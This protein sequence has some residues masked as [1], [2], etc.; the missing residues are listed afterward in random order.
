MDIKTTFPEEVWQGRMHE[1][2]KLSILLESV[3]GQ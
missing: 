3:G 2:R 1:R